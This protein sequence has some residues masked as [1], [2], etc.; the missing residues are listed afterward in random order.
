MADTES[1][2]KDWYDRLRNVAFWYWEYQRRNPSYRKWSKIIQGY[3]RY[4]DL[5]GELE[6]LVSPELF[7]ENIE[8]AQ[9]HEGEDWQS[10]Y[11]RYL[12]DT[13]GPGA[14]CKYF[15]LSV[16]GVKFDE[17]FK[18]VYREHWIGMD[19]DEALDD[20]LDMKSVSFYADDET[21]LIALLSMHEEWIVQFG[22][23]AP[24]YIGSFVEKQA[25]APFSPDATPEQVMKISTEY[26]VLNAFSKAVKCAFEDQFIDDQT[27]KA[28]YKLSIAGRHINST[29][30]VR[31]AILWMWDYAHKANPDDLVSEFDNALVA[32]RKKIKDKDMD[33]EKAF[34]QFTDR[35]ARVLGYFNATNECIQ[36][37]RVFNLNI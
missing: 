10:P 8:H 9:S 30:L 22:E 14:K 15:R 18:R 2:P 5:I 21:D 36:K 13:Y 24:S 32:V 25:T 12:S 20:I 31:L 16:R 35:R 26:Q 27:M 28:V 7:L 17:K 37:M 29:D 33:G 23:E 6:N 4:F 1:V 11:V 34:N 3:L 19:T